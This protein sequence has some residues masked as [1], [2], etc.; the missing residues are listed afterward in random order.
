MTAATNT[1]TTPEA[2][3]RTVWSTKNKVGF[4]LAIVNAIVNLPSVFFPTDTGGND[5]PPFAIML[6]CTILS[7]VALPATIVAWRNGSR[8]ANRLAAASLIVVTL[9]SLPA[10]FVDVPAG[11]KLA[12]AGGVVWTIAMVVLMFAPPKRG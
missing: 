10:F 1:A 3:T 6:V 2:V 11:L 4:V 7:A 9:T 5:G 12:V 8:P